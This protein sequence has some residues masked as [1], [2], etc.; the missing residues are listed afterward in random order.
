[1]SKNHLQYDFTEGT[2]NLII[3]TL[4]TKPERQEFFHPMLTLSK[5]KEYRYYFV[6]EVKDQRSALLDTE[7][8]NEIY[9]VPYS[10]IVA[11]LK[12]MVHQI[13]AKKDE[14]ER[15]F[16]EQTLLLASYEDDGYAIAVLVVMRDYLLIV[17]SV[18]RIPLDEYKSKRL[19][20]YA[21]ERKLFLNDLDLHAYKEER[22]ERR[23]KKRINIVDNFPAFWTDDKSE[24]SYHYS[25]TK[26]L[27]EKRGNSSHVRL[28][29]PV[30]AVEDILA[31]TMQHYATRLKEYM[32][33]STK[34]KQFAIIFPSLDKKY[35]VGILIAIDDV[36]LT[37]IS[38]YDVPPHAKG[39]STLI[40]PSAKRIVL[41]KYDLEK[42]IH[43]YKKEERVKTKKKLDTLKKYGRITKYASLDA[44]DIQRKKMNG[45]PK[46][47]TLRKLKI[48]EKVSQTV[49][50]VKHKKITRPVYLNQKFIQSLGV[51]I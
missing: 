39:F 24:I 43:R 13:D 49:E 30:S 32:G 51:K 28:T 40:F 11:T 3:D 33:Q 4:S 2:P 8:Y 9:D 26:H 50:P 46:N 6:R 37:V 44:Y 15:G 10:Y 18:E 5:E 47:G 36:L 31:Y 19:R 21:L 16:H 23:K 25:C 34:E 20:S 14:G 7:T 38:M 45:I 42:F 27:K 29:I 22:Q 41:T 17:V 48:V 35:K 1:M 12:Y